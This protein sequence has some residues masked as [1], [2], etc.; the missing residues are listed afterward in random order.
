MSAHKH[1]ARARR[2]VRG[3]GRPPRR[4]RRGES[5]TVVL[6][7]EAGVGKSALLDYAIGSAQ[8]FRVLR[9][10]G[11]ESE[12][13]LAFASLH[14]LCAPILDRRDSLPGPQREALEVA[15]GL[16]GGPA[17]DR[18]LVGLATLSLLADVADERPL[19]CVI[20]DAQWLDGASALAFAFVARRLMA[21]PIGLMFAVREP[22][23]VHELAGLPRADDRRPQRRRCAC[24]PGLDAARTAGRA[25]ARPHRRRVTR[26]PAGVARVAARIDPGRA[27][28]RLRASRRAAPGGPYR[29][30]ASSGGSVAS[31]GFAAAAAHRG[32]GAVRGPEPVVASG[33]PTG[34]RTRGGR[35]GGGCGTCSS[36]APGCGSVIRWCARRSTGRHPRPT[37]KSHIGRWPRRSTPTSIPIAGHGT[38]RRRRRGPTRTS[39]WSSS[40]RQVGRRLVAASRRRPRSS[41]APPR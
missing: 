33:G 31:R 40:A 13:E 1:P 2:G 14:Q 26:Q 21:E 7:G 24:A 32:G 22:I 9:S 25:R 36:S 30:R 6:R 10:V 27:G 37:A 34:A 19:L 11:V 12:M 38:V 4:G 39:P 5:R 28:G 23:D 18:F 35:T 15:F 16:D 20:D 8:D 17:P 41:S 3:A 29:A